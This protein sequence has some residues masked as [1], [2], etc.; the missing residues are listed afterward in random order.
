MR[1]IKSGTKRIRKC[2]CNCVFEYDVNDIYK[3]NNNN[4]IQQFVYCPECGCKINISDSSKFA[5]IEE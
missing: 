2:T 4:E 5:S 1:V 3:V